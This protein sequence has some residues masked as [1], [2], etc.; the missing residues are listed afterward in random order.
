[1]LIQEIQCV[2]T[3][4]SGVVQILLWQGGF[5][6]SVVRVFS[7][8]KWLIRCLLGGG[9]IKSDILNFFG[10]YLGD[11]LLPRCAQNALFYLLQLALSVRQP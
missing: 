11:R 2:I 8:F 7:R 3:V 6:E 4:T 9:I 5:T 1:M 10:I